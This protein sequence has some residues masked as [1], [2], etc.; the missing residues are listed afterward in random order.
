MRLLSYDPKQTHARKLSSLPAATILSITLVSDYLMSEDTTNHVLL[1]STFSKSFSRKNT[2][3]TPLT[4]KGS[5]VHKAKYNKTKENRFTDKQGTLYEFVGFEYPRLQ[6]FV[7]I[8]NKVRLCNFIYGYA[9]TGKDTL[10]YV[11]ATRQRYTGNNELVV[12]L[13]HF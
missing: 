13:R 1:D 12:D 3:F 2:T 9:P 10:R 5:P 4:L 11:F 7:K 8:S 6:Y